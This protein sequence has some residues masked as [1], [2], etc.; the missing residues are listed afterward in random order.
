MDYEGLNAV[1]PI[2]SPGHNMGV[3]GT[4]MKPLTQSLLHGDGGDIG[5]PDSPTY[6]LYLVSGERVPRSDGEPWTKLNMYDIFERSTVID[7][8][9]S[10]ISGPESLGNE[11]G[12]EHPLQL[13]RRQVVPY[14]VYLNFSV[15]LDDGELKGHSFFKMNILTNK[16]Y[17]A[18]PEQQKKIDNIVKEFILSTGVTSG[19]LQLAKFALKTSENKLERDGADKIK[20]NEPEFVIASGGQVFAISQDAQ[21]RFAEAIRQFVSKLPSKYYESYELSQYKNSS[22]E[23]YEWS[24]RLGVD[25]NP[26]QHPTG[27]LSRI[28]SPIRRILG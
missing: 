10:P 5:E 15:S 23:L 14:T 8:Y 26:A 24:K 22:G 18:N 13:V 21:K 17:I 9:G 1:G 6:A 4:D 25:P 3:D 27:I 11:G 28:L 20:V 19:T 7:E 2:F 12:E 16:G